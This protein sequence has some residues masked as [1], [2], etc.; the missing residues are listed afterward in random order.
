[1]ELKRLFEPLQVQNIV[2]K[3]RIIMPAIH[4]HYTPDGYA[5]DRFNRYYWRR[6]E[7]GAALIIV[8]GCRF[9]AY[10]G[11]IG[12]MSLQ[13]DS[14]IDGYRAFT[15]GMHARGALVGVQLYHAGAYA[16]R[17][18]IKNG[19]PA[20]SPSA[21]ISQFTKAP[22]QE[23]SVAEIHH[24][25]QLWTNAAVRAQRA[26]FD[27]VEISASAGYL[28]SQFLSPLKNKRTD[29]YGGSWENRTR[30][31]R[32][33]VSTIRSAVGPQYPIGMRVSGDA[34][35]PGAVS[36]SETVL[37]CKQM[38]E[39]GVDILN[40]TGGWH[41]SKVPQITGDV[42]CGGFAYLAAAVRDAV[43]IPVAVSNR[44]N[45]PGTAERLLSTGAGDAV[46]VGRALIADPDWVKKAQAGALEEIRRCVACNQ[47]CLGK[48]FF[49]QPVECA[50]NAE[51]GHEL[52]WERIKRRTGI[53]ILVVGGGPT[54]C[55]FALYAAR[56]G[57]KVTLWERTGSLGGQLPIVAQPPGKQEYRHLIPYYEATLSK[58]GVSVEKSRTAEAREI[59]AAGYDAVVLATGAE[60][61]HPKLPGDNSVP[62]VTA[63][64][65]L[66]RKAIAGSHV[67]VVGGGSVGCETAQYLARES[68]LT[69]EESYFL[70]SKR[71]VG[72]SEVLRLMDLSRRSIGIV[73]I[74]AIGKGFSP[75]TG[76]PV[77]QEL[78]RLGV[79]QYPQHRVEDISRG[80]VIL[81]PAENG[82]ETVRVPCD[83]IV[84]AVGSV[85]NDALAR[86]LEAQGMIVY[87]LGDANHV[88]TIFSAVH[89]AFQL[90]ATI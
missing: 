47:G 14:Y 80:V 90:A 62:V 79:Q 71:A 26:G 50:I 9:D 83:T 76:W 36:D 43:H 64:D 56:L 86:A 51:A 70:L 73:D 88:G 34:F 75:G 65:I 46:S 25:V 63:N 7:G 15:D 24:L 27:M 23:I 32:E 42:P 12:M 68:A 3:N 16:P 29:I 19:A 77:M 48:A 87:R 60:V 74:A 67:L 10:G 61:S 45:D 82:Q 33:V 89:Q 5:T 21:G 8:G 31:A 6:A 20:L 2:L 11:A 81:A 44:I 57:H 84:T 72:S 53:R 55:T 28:I 49:A 4:H 69:P 85:P 17:G 1:M 37:F 13:D 78:D 54:G 40:V 59:L 38:E 52:E 22:V 35:V 18:A 58:L 39:Y 41:E 30:L 66:S